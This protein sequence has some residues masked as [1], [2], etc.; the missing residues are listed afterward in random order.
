MKT[1][2]ELI[3][4]KKTTKTFFFLKEINHFQLYLGNLTLQD[5]NIR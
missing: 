1:L 3:E 4:N 2:F 5:K